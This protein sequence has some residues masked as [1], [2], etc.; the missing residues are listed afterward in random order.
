MIMNEKTLTYK[1][2]LEK[3]KYKSAYDV[4]AYELYLIINELKKLNGGK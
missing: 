3:Y 4:I 2:F 1:E